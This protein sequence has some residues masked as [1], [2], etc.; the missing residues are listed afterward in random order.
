M[1][2][3]GRSLKEESFAMMK[4]MR[5]NIFQKQF[6]DILVILGSKAKEAGTWELPNEKEFGVKFGSDQKIPELLTRLMEDMR[7][8]VFEHGVM[9]AFC[10]LNENGGG[11]DEQGRS[12]FLSPLNMIFNGFKKWNYGRTFGPLFPIEKRI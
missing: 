1:T 4:L 9:K 2:M 8:D 6:I 3:F 10:V 5:S 12:P 11:I 7:E